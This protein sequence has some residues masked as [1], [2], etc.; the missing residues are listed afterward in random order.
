VTAF[1]ESGSGIAEGGRTGLT[2][3]TT[4]LC[5]IISIFF[6]PIF[7][8]IP[9]WATGCTLVLVS[10]SPLASDTT[11]TVQIGCMM[12]RQ[13]IAINWTYIGDA[14][15]AFVTLMFLPFSYL[16]AYGLIAYVPLHPQRKRR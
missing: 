9:L 12:M 15:P 13:V 5:F 11:L 1:I 3:V 8:S 4:G 7:A 6:A 10:T 16:I 2:A 14:V